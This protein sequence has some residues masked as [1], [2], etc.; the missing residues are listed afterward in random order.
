MSATG[1]LTPISL[2]TAIT[3]TSAVSGRMAF[4]SCYGN[5]FSLAAQAYPMNFTSISIIPFVLT[6][7]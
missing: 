3:E 6:G 4:S 7:R 2:F 5:E 1:C